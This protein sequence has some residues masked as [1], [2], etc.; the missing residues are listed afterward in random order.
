[1]RLKGTE[2][3]GLRRWFAAL[4]FG[5]VASV[6]PAEAQEFGA[7]VLHGP[8]LEAPRLITKPSGF[9][10]CLWVSTYN[11]YLEEGAEEPDEDSYLT[12]SF[13]SPQLVD[14][15]FVDATPRLDALPI[16]SARFHTRFYLTP[17]DG[18]PPPTASRKEFGNGPFESRH[19][20]TPTSEL[21]LA[22]FGIPTRF[23][24]EG[25]P[26]PRQFTGEE[27][28]TLLEE[29]S[30]GVFGETLRRCFVGE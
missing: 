21:V 5:F 13:F 23:D 20:L 19:F 7:V 26:A 1:M 3:T 2:R 9:D 27:R 24:E 16:S 30:K 17:R 4:C 10:G 12:L 29:A 14:S 18:G 15:L 25:V 28:A 22:E 8:I 11:L 6:S